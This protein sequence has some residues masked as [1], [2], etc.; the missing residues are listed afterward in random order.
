VDAAINDRRVQV[1]PTGEMRSEP[2]PVSSVDSAGFQR[3]ERAIRGAFT[4]AVVVPGLV[5][6]ATDC[7]HYAP[8]SQDAYRFT[9]IWVR[10]DDLSRVHGANERLS[11]ENYAQVIGFYKE[12]MTGM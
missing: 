2:S 1:R 4:Q 3:L 11:V 10:P 5:M 6:G 7:R 8:L 9:P 12:M